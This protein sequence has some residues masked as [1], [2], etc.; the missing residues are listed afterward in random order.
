V[1]H[2]PDAARARLFNLATAIDFVDGRPGTAFYFFFGNA[3]RFI[4]FFGIRGLAFLFSGVGCF[5][6]TRYGNLLVLIL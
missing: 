3:S 1:I 2:L 6:A 5:A 4:S